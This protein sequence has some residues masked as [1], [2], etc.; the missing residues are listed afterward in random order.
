MIFKLLFNVDFHFGCAKV[1]IIS[2]VCEKIVF[3]KKKRENMVL[4]KQ[5]R[6]LI[7][8]LFIRFKMPTFAA[9]FFRR[10]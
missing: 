7:N 4:V 10:N 5:K 1:Q 9:K 3:F 8:L 6:N 2:I